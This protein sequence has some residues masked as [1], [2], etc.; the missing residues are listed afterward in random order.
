MSRQ[1]KL[2]E[3]LNK[4]NTDIAIK[5]LEDLQSY[6]KDMVIV[7]VIPGPERWDLT[8]PYI[9]LPNGQQY[10]GVM[11]IRDYVKEQLSTI[12]DM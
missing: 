10:S 1:I 8:Y 2:F 6:D 3:S 9:E 5:W 4:A 12:M 11:S 7:H